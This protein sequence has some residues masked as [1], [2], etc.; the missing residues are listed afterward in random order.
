MFGSNFPIEKIWTD[1]QTLFHGTASILDELN[2][3]EKAAVLGGTAKRIYR[4]A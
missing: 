4:P 3:I 1:Y 2:A